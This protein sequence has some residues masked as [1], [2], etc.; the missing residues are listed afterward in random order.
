[1]LVIHDNLKDQVIRLD[2]EMK[3]RNRKSNNALPKFV[4]TRLVNKHANRPYRVSVID[5]IRNRLVQ[6]HVNPNHVLLARHRDLLLD[7]HLVAQVEAQNANRAVVHSD[8]D[9]LYSFVTLSTKP[10]MPAES[11]LF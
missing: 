10:K 9:T 4:P 3:F 8:T 6:N 1:M 2:L 11:G 5:S 7:Q